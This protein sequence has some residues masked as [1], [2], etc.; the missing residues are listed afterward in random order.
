MRWYAHALFGISSLWLLTPLLNQGDAAGVAN[1]GVLAACAAFGALL[2]DLDAS[3]SKIK[4][5][6]LA[7]TSF[8]PFLLPSHII[9]HS[10]RHRGLLHSLHERLIQLNSAEIL[11]F[12]LIASLA[13]HV[14]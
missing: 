4:H 11:V 12:R 3:D 9:H 8:K 2:P 10:D 1:I 6:K 14:M 7:G 13:E 5:L